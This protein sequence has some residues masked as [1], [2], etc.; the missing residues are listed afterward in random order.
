M[1]AHVPA[2]PMQA[3]EVVMQQSTGDV[4]AIVGGR[5]HPTALAFDWA[6]AAPGRQPG[7]SIKPIVDYI[8]A[9][10]HGLTAGTVVDDVLQA[11]PANSLH[12]P[13]LLGTLQRGDVA[14]GVIDPESTWQRLRAAIESDLRAPAGAATVDAVGPRMGD[15]G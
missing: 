6:L 7:S 8:P 13:V 10:E 12:G 15:A 4:V 2:A 11:E 9:L 1:T 14:C 3:A 5:D